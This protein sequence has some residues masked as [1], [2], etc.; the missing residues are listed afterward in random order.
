MNASDQA[1]EYARKMG[2]K[3]TKRQ[4]RGGQ[5]IKARVELYLVMHPELERCP[6]CGQPVLAK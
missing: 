5:R 6:N 1:I 3:A 4:L 2:D